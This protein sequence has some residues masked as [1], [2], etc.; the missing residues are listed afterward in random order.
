MRHHAKAAS[1]GSTEA[2][3]NSRGLRRGAL[4]T[5]GASGDSDG[6]GAPSYGHAL[7]AARRRVLPILGIASALLLILGVS[8]AVAATPE[9]KIDPTVVPGYTKAEVAGEINTHEE[10][11]EYRFE[12]ST[13]GG[14]TWAP[15]NLT[16]FEFNEALQPIPGLGEIEGLNPGTTY[17]VRL[18]ANNFVEE[19]STSEAENP[20]F[21]TK[22]VAAPSA[23]LDPVV[24][25][26]ATTADLTGTV[27]PNSP[28]SLDQAGKEAYATSYSFHCSPECP[29]LTGGT[30]AA[31]AGGSEL[32]V[33]AH[34]TG[35]EPN[36]EYTVT[37]V[38]TNGGGE[39]TDGPQSFTTDAVPPTV[40]AGTASSRTDGVTQI[41]GTVNPHNSAISSC[42]FEYGM[43]SA[44][45]QTAVCETDPGAGRKPVFVT[46]SLTGLE[47][48]ITYH[49]RLKALSAGGAAS[50][51]DAS[52]A[53]SPC[54]NEAIREEQGSTNL[55]EC[56]AYEQVSPLF[57]E[58]F[59]GAPTGFTDDGALTYLSNGNYA[60]NGNGISAE[61]GGN[62]Y[63]A[64]R[65]MGGW[66]TTS[67]APS[68]QFVI[69]SLETSSLY[70]PSVPVA[71]SSD[72]RS[73]VWNIRRLDQPVGV[74]DLYV[75]DPD[76]VFTRIGGASDQRAGGGVTSTVSASAD[77][78]HVVFST[79]SGE[80]VEYV[81]ADGPRRPV[82]VDNSGQQLAGGPE[83]GSTRASISTD[84]HVVFFTCSDSN[85][86]SQALYARVDGTTT[87]EV[88]GS[89]CTR[90]PADLGGPCGAHAPPRFA[91]ENADGTR[92]YFTTAQ[93]LVNGD[94]DQT[95]DLYECDIPAGTLAPVGA[96][97]PCPDLR[98]VSGAQPGANARPVA[99]SE[100][101]THAYFV[102]TGVL[103]SNLGAN[104]APAVQGDENL[105]VW[106][107]DAA[108]PNGETRFVAKL[109]P[110][111]PGAAQTTPNGRYLVFES[112]ARLIDH[113]PQADTDSARDLYRYDAETGELTRL[114]VE[115]DG[116]GG[117]ESGQNV[118]IIR[119]QH[120][121]VSDDGS[122]AV[123]TTD[124]ALAPEDTNGTIDVYLWHDGVVSLI[125]SGKPSDDH[126]IPL[127]GIEG[128]FGNYV[129]PEGFISPSGRDVFFTTTRRMI[130]ADVDTVMDTYDDRIDGGFPSSETPSCIGESCRASA[131]PPPGTLRST[132]QGPGAGNPVPRKSCPK[133][134]AKKG[135]HCVK[136]PGK[137]RKHRAKKHGTKDRVSKHR[138]AARGG[139]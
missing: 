45:G 41:T 39:V 107:H 134:K 95:T 121:A 54:P 20:E 106:T 138:A 40:T 47:S 137:K 77:L 51:P 99:I 128:S 123:F 117:N 75:R 62:A 118:F 114:S 96:L 60:N 73:T 115:I 55:P 26:T 80:T 27:D 58:G 52:F 88:S 98:E 59:A 93:Q 56:R 16:N 87:V 84:G 86:I 31:E 72:R 133:G 30:V 83:C 4:A 18:T 135:G 23:S 110:S 17:K 81:D 79:Q 116:Q 61:P 119:Y 36:T 48:G 70:A 25:K 50:S 132:T 122:S 10:F 57:K 94:T 76:G 104:E 1:A 101:G 108:H 68:S 120:G 38:A 49:F 3:G 6:S 33:E 102:A 29:G 130:S 125:S 91:G 5:R 21:T 97:N 2:G 12:V 129:A 53:A 111:D 82:S 43:T 103:A 71:Y 139:R 32:E 11:I 19:V 8:S 85:G 92:I 65:T 105:Y 22:L 44:Y 67:L 66:S 7:L 15:T 126:E 37:L 46:A 136:K 34:A 90:G 112:Y 124:E 127:L 28:G 9:V 131:S 64:T 113:G 78:S 13:D 63:L 109:A 35:L 89:Q 69:P 100:D 42:L 14:A 74:M 24:S